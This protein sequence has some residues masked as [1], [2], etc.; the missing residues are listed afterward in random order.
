MGWASLL[1]PGSGFADFIGS[2]TNAIRGFGTGLASGQNISDGLAAGAQGAAAGATQDDAFATA[3][4]AEQ[5]QQ[6]AINK[7]AQFLHAKGYDDLVPL[8]NAGQASTALTEAFKRMAPGYGDK[9]VSAGDIVL[10]PDNQPVFTAPRTPSAAS[11]PSGYE[12]GPPDPTTGRATLQPIL[13][14]PADPSSATLL[15][16]EALDLLAGQYLTGDKSAVVGFARSPAMKTQLTNAIAA[17]A[18]EMG[19]DGNAD[20]GCRSRPTAATSAAQR[21]AGTRAAQVGMAASEANQMADI[22]LEASKTVARAAISCHGTHCRQRRRHRHQLARNGGLRHGD[23]LAGQRL[24]PRGV[25]ARRPDRC[26]APACRGR[27]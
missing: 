14:G 23:D 2:N 12:P 3:K 11:I 16:P 19:M 1:F 25:A 24:C 10:G 18:K 7:T 13:H 8:V 5:K 26:D 4:K 27:C 17:K 15:S 9:T 20:R 21:A 6:D 22:A